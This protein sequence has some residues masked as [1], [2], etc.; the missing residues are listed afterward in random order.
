MVFSR[1]YKKIDD[2]PKWELLFHNAIF[3]AG[4]A[5]ISAFNYLYY[6]VLSRIV[7]VPS[8]GEIQALISLFMQF[9]V[10][11]TAFGYM[12][13]N[14]VANSNDTQTSGRY[15]NWLEKRV[16]LF[17]IAIF[18][19]LTLASSYFG[20]EF[21][22]TS[23]WPVILIGILLIINVPATSRSFI[24][25]A[26][27]RLG[28]LSIAGV[29]FAIGKLF[30]GVTFI[31]LFTDDVF[32]AITGYV[33]AQIV[34]LAYV[35]NKTRDVYKYSVFK[36]VVQTSR[37]LSDDHITKGHIHYGLAILIILSGLALL[38]TSDTII[39]RL[40]FDSHTL[41]IYSGI[42]SIARII[43]FV[44]ASVAAVLL[45]SVT[46]RAGRVVNNTALKQSLLIV[47]LVGGGVAL[48]FTLFPEIFVKTLIGSQYL[49]GSEWLPILSLVMLVCSINNLLA[50]YQIALRRKKTIIP[51]TA[52]IVS[53]TI[54]LTCY[55]S[56]IDQFIGVFLA[57]NLLV[58]VLLSM[59]IVLENK[60]GKDSAKETAVDRIAEL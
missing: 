49:D 52:G 43:Y 23:V 5:L 36:S 20:S 13:T 17:C 15:I 11:L 6:P 45:A 26:Q 3:F 57:S 42:S 41:G 53:L 44:T 54:G 47:G 18:A 4:T 50:I 35:R 32:A 21:K 19:I 12:V 40:F 10:V 1:I 55:H 37:K 56:S 31:W 29:V 25:Q 16:L 60:R 48:V 38:Y 46:I 22:I 33:I 7:D 24:L 9:G 59:E 51:V 39:A 30:L 58:C 34:M 8:F 27:K 14:I 28:T 2:N